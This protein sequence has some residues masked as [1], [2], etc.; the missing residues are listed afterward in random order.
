MTKGNRFSLGL[1]ASVLALAIGILFG[2]GSYCKGRTPQDPD[3][4]LAE[5][6]FDRGHFGKAAGY[7][8]KYLKTHPRD[9]LVIGK[10]AKCYNRCGSDELA[11]KEL[12]R[13]L[14]IDPKLFWGYKWRGET[15]FSL[16]KFRDAIADF[17]RARR[18]PQ[19]KDQYSLSRWMGQAYDALG[20]EQKAFDELARSIRQHAAVKENRP[21]WRGEHQ[22]LYRIR[23]QTLYNHKHYEEAIQDLSEAIKLGARGSFSEDITMTRA[24]S[25]MALR[26]YDDAIADYSTILK[27]SPE[28]EVAFEKRA[29]AYEAKGEHK[30]ALSDI[31]KAISNYL[32][33]D[34]SKLYRFR[35]SIHTRLGNRARAQQDLDRASKKPSF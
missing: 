3:L 9:A 12:D 6:L 13:A 20:Q 5:R 21:S 1:S 33:E 15:N 23:G 22:D 25:Y 16:G 24:D 2:A 14:R 17:E 7:Y 35:A 30:R 31:S 26:R 27:F 34:K 4:S 11:L 18:F 10:R 8:T 32:G 28:D 29:H 19:G